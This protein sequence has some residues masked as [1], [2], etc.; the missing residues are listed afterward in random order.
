MKERIGVSWKDA[1]KAKKKVEPKVF[2][3]VAS[4]AENWAFRAVASMDLKKVDLSVAMMAV[5]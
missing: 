3:S 4:K 2:V 5:R 1:K